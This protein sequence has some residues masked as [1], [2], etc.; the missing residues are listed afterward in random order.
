MIKNHMDMKKSN[1]PMDKLPSLKSIKVFEVA[2]RQLSFSR[3][4]DELCV[5]Q[6]AVSHQIR[7][8]ENHLGKQL[9]IRANNS[10]FLSSYGEILAKGVK[11]SFDI[12]RTATNEVVEVSDITIKVVA[13]TSVALDWLAP[14]LPKFKLQNPEVDVILTTVTSSEH[15]EPSEFHVSIGNWSTPPDFN[16][17]RIRKEN[18]FPVVA[19]K[20][21]KKI[22]IENAQSI[23]EAPLFSYRNGNDWEVWMKHHNL[24]PKTKL[25]I[26]HFNDPLL[27]T[28]AA[29]SG[30]GVALS[31]MFIAENAIKENKLTH[32]PFL[33]NRPPW[34]D[35]YIHYLSGSYYINLFTNW[36]LSCCA[37]LD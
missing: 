34:G 2:A 16:S 36:V 19:S 14:R 17:T 7:S 37:E 8:L 12:L 33:S 11:E 26:Q 21:S 6:S 3:A 27:A 28:K 18:W 22:N 24:K 4:A 29:L 31:N 35:Y 9:F 25:N 30:E 10:V 23:L 1:N 15:Y 5:S 32:N 13:Q 20:T